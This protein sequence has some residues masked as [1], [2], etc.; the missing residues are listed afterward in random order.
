[1]TRVGRRTRTPLW[2]RPRD[3]FRSVLRKEDNSLVPRGP[4]GSRARIGRAHLGTTTGPRLCPKDQPQQVRMPKV[5]ELSQSAWPR[6]AAAAGAPHGLL[7]VVSCA[8]E[9]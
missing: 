2:K 9:G 8:I 7:V 5:A 4:C 1:M 6:R 3:V